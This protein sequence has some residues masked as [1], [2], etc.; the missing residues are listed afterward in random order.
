MA[1]NFGRNLLDLVVLAGSIYLMGKL[2]FGAHG[3]VSAADSGEGGGVLQNVVLIILAAGVAV[4]AVLD[5]IT[6]GLIITRAYG[7]FLSL[8]E[9]EP[10][11]GLLVPKASE[12][13]LLFRSL[14]M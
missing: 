4:G 10:T 14:F 1:A 9:T 6:D 12:M 7:L 13:T 5:L 2:F 3:I 8:F 11:G